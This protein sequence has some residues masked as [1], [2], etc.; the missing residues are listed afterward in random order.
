MKALTLE[1]LMNIKSKPA[2]TNIL[3]V[4]ILNIKRLSYKG[5]FIFLIIVILLWITPKRWFPYTNS[6]FIL[7]TKSISMTIFLGL[8][9]ICAAIHSISKMIITSRLNSKKN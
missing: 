8:E 3:F 7:T 1:N 6:N 4:F 9:I 5:V 2:I